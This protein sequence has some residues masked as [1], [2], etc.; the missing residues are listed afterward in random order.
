MPWCGASDAVRR[1]RAQ[2][3]VARGGGRAD[4][5]AAAIRV[6]IPA[7]PVHLRRC[8]LH[9]ARGAEHPHRLQRTNLSR[10]LRVRRDR[11]V[12]GRALDARPSR[13][14]DVRARPTGLASARGRH[15]RRLHDPV[16]RARCRCVR[17]RVRPARAATRGRV[18]R[19]RDVRVRRVAAAGREAIRGRDRRRRRAGAPTAVDAVRLG[20]FDPPLALLRGLGG[21]G[22]DRPDRVAAAARTHRPRARGAARRRDCRRLGWRQPHGVQDVRL[23]RLGRVRRCGRGVVRDRGGVREPGHVPAQPVN[24]DACEPRT[25]RHGLVVRR[26][27][28]SADH[29]VPAGLRPDAAALARLVFE[30]VAGGRVRGDADRHH[31]HRAGRSRR[32]ASATPTAHDGSAQTAPSG[33]RGRNIRHIK[34]GRNMRKALFTTAAVAAA[35]LVVTLPGALAKTR[36]T[37]GTAATPGVTKSLIT[38]GGTFPLSLS[39]AATLYAPI[40]KGMQIY[41]SWVNSRIN[42]GDRK[43]GVYG[44]Q[45]R[46]KY[47]DDE[48]NPAKTVQFT[49]QLLLQDRV[50]AIVGWQPDYISEGRAY[51][52][53]IAR[54][55][56]NAK[57]A[58]FYQNDDY[59]KDYLNGLKAGLGAKRSLITSEQ[60]YEA[61]ETSYASQIA[62]QKATGANTWVLLTTPTPTGRALGTAKALGWKPDTI[63]INS[64]SAADS[65]M[66][67]LAASAQV[68][69][70]F[71]NGAV[72]TA[73]LKNA[74]N[75]QYA[76]DPWV[77]NYYRV[78]AKYGPGLDARNGFYYYGFAKA[79]DVVRLLYL[80]GKNPTRAS[81][82]A[83][84][85]KMNWV[86]P[87]T[88][89]GVRVK[90]S[91]RDHFPLSQFKLIRWRNGSWAEFGPLVKGR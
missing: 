28:G 88:I 75:P 53:W 31:V 74:T 23:R 78:M 73:Y 11:R 70:D 61:T 2:A 47:Y 89:K 50:F 84:T 58:V 30:G 25:W 1:A 69:A 79:Y 57:I 43:R 16:R 66:R 65:V 26:A 49:N 40:P 87:Y 60:S 27:D 10:P 22:R 8:L 80:A 15:A 82:L 37:T 19:A 35:A 17:L 34:E 36:A 12:H 48:Y 7:Q 33:N 20:H 44:R 14:R 56:P 81:L 55:A 38:I 83:A 3:R 68:G 62:R 6:R 67:S 71:I 77:R 72:S 5:A 54:N 52:Q 9:R 76:K 51:G 85:K 90:T 13:A 42:K 63:V 18:A 39:P 29:A 86:N 21:S 91:A 32:L 4:R 24:P 59:G 41:F 45:I 46:W 64:V